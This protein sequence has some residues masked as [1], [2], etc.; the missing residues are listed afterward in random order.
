MATVPPPVILVLGDSLSA[1]HGIPINAGWV[2]LLAKK[3]QMEGY[4]Y[5]V[6]NASI[7]GNTTADGLSRLPAELKRYHP[8]I[9]VIELGGNDGLRGTP[10]PVFHR[11]LLALATTAKYFGTRVLLL[12]VRLP[13]NYGTVYTSAFH[14]VYFKVAEET[15]SSLV[16]CL[17]RGIAT[18]PKLMQSDGIHPTAKAQELLLN[19]VWPTLTALVKR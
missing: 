16:P 6:I 19:N 18:N 2:H 5:Q 17:L 15:G 12:G 10:I 11:Q 13:P 9:T 14:H 7:S 1:A 4:S 3:L 8:I